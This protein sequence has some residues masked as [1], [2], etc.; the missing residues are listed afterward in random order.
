MYTYRQ[1][2]PPR[3]VIHRAQVAKNKWKLRARFSPTKENREH[4]TKISTKTDESGFSS[5]VFR[6]R[7]EQ[8]TPVTEYLV[9]CVCVLFSTAKSMAKSML[10]MGSVFVS[11]AITFHSSALSEAK[12][13]L[14]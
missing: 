5:T 9:C 8:K 12:V 13:S 11:V 3:V 1:Q 14:A 4:Q 2:A 10:R 7:L 6:S